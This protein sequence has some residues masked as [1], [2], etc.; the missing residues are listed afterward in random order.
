MARDKTNKTNSRV[1]HPIHYNG[2][3]IRTKTNSIVEVELVDIMEALCGHDIHLAQAI[4]YLGRAGRKKTS[5]FNEDI[6]K[7]IWWLTRC[8]NAHGGHPDVPKGE[9]SLNL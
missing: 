7:S 8:V 4:K 2:I 1:N 5:S 6:G 3:K 9:T